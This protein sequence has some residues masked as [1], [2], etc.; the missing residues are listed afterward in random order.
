MINDPCESDPQWVMEG[1]GSVT[2]NNILPFSSVQGIYLYIVFLCKHVESVHLKNVFIKLQHRILY[3]QKSLHESSLCVVS[4]LTLSSHL[5]IA[6][7]S[8][9]PAV[10]IL[11][12]VVWNFA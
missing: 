12:V 2:C 6:L 11:F 4:L 9:Q 10:V 8:C 3:F 1:K 5:F 7:G